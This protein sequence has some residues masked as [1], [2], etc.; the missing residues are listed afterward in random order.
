MSS[1]LGPASVL[2]T[3]QRSELQRPAAPDSVFEIWM[4]S[5][6]IKGSI[7]QFPQLL[8]V[9]APKVSLS[10]V[11]SAITVTSNVN[12]A[13]NCNKPGNWTSINNSNCVQK[14]PGYVS[15]K[16]HS[17]FCLRELNY[18]C[19]LSWSSLTRFTT[20]ARIRPNKQPVLCCALLSLESLVMLYVV[21]FEY[22]ENFSRCLV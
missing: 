21:S 10:L 19:W 18:N 16:L 22:F 12:Y 6:S 14:S 2:L 15:P 4:S 8:L 11:T 13:R 5:L 9:R 20:L 1:E 17:L 3:R 7:L